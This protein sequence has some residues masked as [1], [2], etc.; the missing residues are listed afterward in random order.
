[1]WELRED[2]SH[3]H[4]E[5]FYFETYRLIWIMMLTTFDWFVR[6]R[7]SRFYWLDNSGG[8]ALMTA[9][10]SDLY[11]WGAGNDFSRGWRF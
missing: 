10:G 7:L 8:G 11:R 4:Y 9:V 1:M 5:E 2:E 3:R 6:R